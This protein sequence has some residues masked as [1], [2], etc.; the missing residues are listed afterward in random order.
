MSPSA[1]APRTQATPHRYPFLDTSAWLEPPATPCP[2]LKGEAR[3]E[4]LIVGGGYT[5]LAT[6]LALKEAGVDVAL[7]EMDYCG[8]GASGR[9][10]GHLTPTI[11]KDLPTLVRY[12]GKERAAE[13]ARFSDRAVRHTEAMFQKYSIDCD[14]QPVG[15]IV[16]GMHPR[17]R[18][19]LER[20][21]EVAGSLGVGVRFLPEAEMRQ[22]QIPSAFRFGV[23]EHCGGHL[24][25]GKYLLGL[26]QAALAAG[27]R[28]H[29]HSRV[30]RIDESAT[31]VR[32]STDQGQLLA[33][34]LVVAT[35]AYTPA[36]LGRLKGHLFPLRVSLFRTPVLS[37]AQREA[38]GW[39]GR[40]GIY[41]AHES[42]ESYRLSA[43]QRI[44]GGSKFIQY[45]YGSR[46]VDGYLPEVFE[47]HRAL[48]A[49]RFPEVPGLAIEAHWGGWVGIT[50]DF[51]PMSFSNTRGNVYYGLGYN[52]HGIAQA[53]LNGSML[54]DQVL[55][56]ANDDVER[57][58]RRVLPLPPE[59][60][61][62][63]GVRAL[64]WYYERIDRIVD[65]DLRLR[66]V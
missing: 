32:V 64:Q 62:W 9:N 34:K 63:L 50:L 55:G 31:P 10:A 37:P 21:A 11:G 43:D 25:P 18:A 29:E 44:V 14:Y 40:E 58:K 56:R 39:Q 28:I 35:N 66:R 30:T 13:F 48:L 15:N 54:A 26:R 20:A 42:L 33:E 4:V 38:L 61:R 51:L 6:A 19:P 46:M 16:G 17:H 47:Q 36:T 8:K 27:V 41:T 57:L 22:R 12:V 3:A 60:L 53:T 49:L 1:P 2:P 24:H 23:L 7:L 5:G 65:A 45:G 59:P 52:G